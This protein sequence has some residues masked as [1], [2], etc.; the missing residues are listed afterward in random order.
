MSEIRLE[1][2]LGRRVKDRDGQVIGRIE[3]VHV[4]QSVDGPAGDYE[5]TEYLLGPG[6]LLERLSLLNRLLGRAPKTLVVRWDQLDITNP[7]EPRLTCDAGDLR[8]EERP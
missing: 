8:R 1:D 3:E 5:I 6:A 2:L 4:E 7:S